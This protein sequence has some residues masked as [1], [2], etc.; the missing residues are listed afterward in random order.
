MAEMGF[1]V[2][3]GLVEMIVELLSKMKREDIL[4]D[5]LAALLAILEEGKVISIDPTPM[6]NPY[7]N[8][9]LECGGCPVL[10]RLQNFPNDGVYE[11]VEKILKDFVDK[12]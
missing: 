12:M 9:L 1:L 3:L 5:C 2:D 11:K 7:F 10:E 8:K 6:G 4:I